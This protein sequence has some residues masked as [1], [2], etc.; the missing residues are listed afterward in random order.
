M[1]AGF[2]FAN[3]NRAFTRSSGGL[4]CVARKTRLHNAKIRLPAFPNPKRR[5]L[6]VYDGQTKLGVIID[7]ASSFEAIP[8]NNVSLGKS[9]TSTTAAAS[10]LCRHALR[11]QR[12]AS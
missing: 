4:L 12:R 11:Q 10:A 8:A 6:A 1:K 5:T 2:S 3:F 7:R 9:F